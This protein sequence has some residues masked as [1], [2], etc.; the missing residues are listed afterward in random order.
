MA[1]IPTLVIHYKNR[2]ETRPEILSSPIPMEILE[3]VKT[4]FFCPVLVTDYKSSHTAP[5][6]RNKSTPT[7]M[8]TYDSTST[9]MEG[10]WPP[11]FLPRTRNT[12]SVH[13]KLGTYIT[14]LALWDCF[15]AFPCNW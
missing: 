13:G 1:N 3:W 5:L 12:P 15:E 10:H 9:N 14:Y 4:I 2:T 6:S 7:T 11:T 8:A